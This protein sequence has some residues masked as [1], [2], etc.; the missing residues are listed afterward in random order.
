M[1]SKDYYQALGIG[2]DAS[3]KEIKQAYRR[4]ARKYHPDLNPDDKEAE[5]KF[6]EMN[7]A[8]QVLSDPEKRKKY[9]QYGDQWEYA[10]Q[11]AKSGGQERVRWDFGGGGTTFEYGDADAFGDILSSL[12][13]GAAGGPRTRRGPQRGQD[14]ESTIEVTLEEAY[15]GSKRVIQLQIDEPCTACGGTGR[16]GNRTCTICNG[17]GRKAAPKRLEVKI[18]RGVKD[19]SRIR[20]AGE[21]GHGRAGG[22]K[23]DLYLV[24]KLLTHK[25]FERK[26]DDIHV[27]VP[28]PLVTA[29]LG[30][31]VRVP[32][33]DGDLSLKIPRETQN[34]KVFRLGGKGMPVLGN[35]GHGNMFA[36]A[37][38]VLPTGLTDEEKRLFER[39]RSLRPAESEAR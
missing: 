15:H 14:I 21:G 11:F 34:G 37:K 28:V 2:K 27:E 12:F 18:P 8:Y 6:K 1:K 24:V 31:E 7:A 20:I 19:G 33:L 26:E 9:D 30:G 29:M 36:R 4:L 25:L 3:Q 16:V 17:T 13:G 22:G 35:A 32:T 5:A 39:L 38:V 10:D 23:G